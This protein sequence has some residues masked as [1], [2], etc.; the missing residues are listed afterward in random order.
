MDRQRRTQAG[1]HGD[2][3]AGAIA[4]TLGRDMRETRKRRRLRQEQVSALVG[5]SRSRYAD[6]ERGEGANAPLETWARI[7]AALGR[8]L[9]VGF[10]RD[11]EDPAPRDAGHL[12]AQEQVLRLARAHGR[13]ASFELATRPADPS[14]SSDVALRDDAH[15]VLILGEIQNRLDDLGAAARATDRKVAEAATGPALFAAGDDD[16]Y[17]VASCWL[18]VDTAANRRLVTRYPE[19]IRA[20]FPGSSAAW[21]KCLTLGTEPPREPGVVWIDPRAGRITELRLRKDRADRGSA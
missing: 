16:P 12:A 4:A 2:Q 3:L 17:R 9:A 8:P 18:L 20:R 21:A 11:I 10:S 7:G 13:R 5:I 14:R 19:V 1:V 15:R 6:L